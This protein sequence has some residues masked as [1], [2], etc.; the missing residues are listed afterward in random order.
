MTT[1]SV[2]IPATPRLRD[3]PQLKVWQGEFGRAYTDRN[4]LTPSQLDR[5]CSAN[6]GVSRSEI[7][8]EFLAQIPRHARILEVGCNV[9]NQLLLL[10]EQGFNDLTA[11][12]IQSY[13]IETARQRVPGVLFKQASAFDLPFE[14]ESFDLVFT[15]GVLIHI[16]PPDLGRAMGEIHRCARSYIWGAEYFSAEPAAVNYRGH[17]DLLWKMDYAEMYLSSFSDLK[18]VRE[19]RLRY[20]QNKNVDTVFLL[21]K[22]QAETT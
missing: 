2:G 19:R 10:Q 9:G 15:S 11:V 1:G 13:A 20:L 16:A 22:Y 6:Y 14:K 18:L 17:E 7:N 21:E 3:T 5:L 4:I 8:R 12:E